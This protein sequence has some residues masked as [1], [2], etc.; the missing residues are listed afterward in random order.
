MNGK[1]AFPPTPTLMKSIATVCLSG[2]LPEKLEAPRPLALTAWR[3]SKTT[4]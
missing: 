3:S 4:F 2:T 1:P